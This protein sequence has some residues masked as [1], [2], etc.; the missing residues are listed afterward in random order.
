MSVTGMETGWCY[1]WKVTRTWCIASLLQSQVKNEVT[2]GGLYTQINKPISV[3][4][5]V[6]LSWLDSTRYLKYTLRT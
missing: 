2:V 4:N 5:L 1:D 3:Q 6:T